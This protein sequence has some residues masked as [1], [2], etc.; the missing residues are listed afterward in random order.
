MIVKS[1]IYIFN[2]ISVTRRIIDKRK[3]LEPQENTRLC[4]AFHRFE[5]N[6]YYVLSSCTV[7]VLQNKKSFKQEN[8]ILF[9]AGSILSFRKCNDVT[10]QQQQHNKKDI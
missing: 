7:I 8:I 4:R 9:E 2:N 1:Y 3:G 10:L 5:P 6:L